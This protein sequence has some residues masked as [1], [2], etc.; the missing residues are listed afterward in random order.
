MISRERA[1]LV[2]VLLSGLLVVSACGGSGGAAPPSSAPSSSKDS[3]ASG[4]GAVSDEGPV[5][6]PKDVD[7]GDFTTC[8]IASDGLVRCW[9]RN[10]EGELGDGKGQGERLKRSLVPGVGK[11]TKVALASKFGCAILEDKKV[12]CWG[13]GRIANDGKMVNDAKPT[14]VAGVVDAEELVASGALACAR[15]ASGVVCWG[16]DEKTIGTP[17][18]GAFKQVAVGFTHACA[19]DAAGAVTC[20][21]PP[22]D[23]GAGG[24][25]A[26]PAISGAV[27]V[28]T[29]D[30]HG[31]VVTKSQTVQCWGMNDAGQLGTKPDIEPHKKLVNVPGVTGVKRLIAG[32]ASTCALLGDGSVRCWGSNGEGELGLGTRSSDERPA[33]VSALSAVEDV[34]LASAHGCALTKAGKLLCWGSNAFGQIGDGTKERRPE[35]TP[36]SW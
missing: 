9:G 4:E 27:Q 18:K 15:N 8:A 5:G 29:G 22:G 31:C 14:L 28:V 32:E 3:A 33:R 17:P 23:W 7:C 12:K 6:A 16:A 19:L 35:P 24:I 26:K 13:T 20:W 25:F 1:A 11:V 30:R 10:K 34:C 2:H 36:V 21:G